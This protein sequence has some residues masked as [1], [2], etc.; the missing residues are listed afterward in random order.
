MELLSEEEDAHLFRMIWEPKDSGPESGDGKDGA[1]HVCA[2]TI[3]STCAP[4]HSTGPIADKKR[5][6]N[7]KQILTEKVLGNIFS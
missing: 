6:W 3:K 7:S 1:A 2:S 4:L 5:S